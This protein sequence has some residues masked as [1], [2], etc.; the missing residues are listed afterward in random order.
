MTTLTP[1]ELAIMKSLWQRQDA[2]VRDVQRDLL[3]TRP[4]AY[5][6]VMT[7]L[8]RLF[9]KGLVRR[10]KKSR[11]H[12]YE[13]TVS[14]SEARA[15]AVEGLVEKYFEGSAADLMSYLDGGRTSRRP[16][17]HRTAPP[18]QSQAIDDTLL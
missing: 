1:L 4:L 13:P 3:P 12:L 10:R 7:V 2:L 17:V 5:T 16:P 6:T 15:D 18:A 9:K 11:A 14:E 8:D